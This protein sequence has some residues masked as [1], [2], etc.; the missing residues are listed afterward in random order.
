MASIEI[1]KLNITEI[2]RLM[3]SAIVPRPIAWVSTIDGTGQTNLAPFSYFNAVSSTP[4]SLLFCVTRKPDGSKKDTELNILETR[5]FVVNSSN[6]WNLEMVNESS[7]PYPHGVSEF[8][9]VGATPAASSLVKP[10]RVLQAGVSMECKLLDT[11]QVGQG[12]LGS[13]LIIVGQIVAMH[14]RDDLLI[15]GEIDFEKYKPL[16]RLGGQLY[17]MNTASIEKPRGVVK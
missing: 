9:K 6:E 17:G 1:S 7:A 8:A 5:E 2:Y 11:L 3:I 4:P 12:N 13:S 10:P 16:S 14:V 15:N